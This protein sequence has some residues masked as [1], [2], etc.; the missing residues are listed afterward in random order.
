[1]LSALLCCEVTERKG[2]TQAFAPQICSAKRN[3]RFTTFPP[4]RQTIRGRVPVKL[5]LS[6]AAV[7]PSDHHVRLQYHLPSAWLR[8]NGALT[9][10]HLRFF[11]HHSAQIQ[12]RIILLHFF[13]LFNCLTLPF[14][15]RHMMPNEMQKY[16]IFRIITNSSTNI[17]TLFRMFNLNNAS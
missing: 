8:P 9:L 1:M 10:H 17:T 3:D 16:K 6:N 14:S 12:L 5:R 4:T 13:V 11:H 2:H 7:A 15:L